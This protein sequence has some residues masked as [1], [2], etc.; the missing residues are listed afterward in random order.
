MLNKIKRIAKKSRSIQKLWKDINTKVTF[1]SNITEIT[2][3]SARRGGIIEKRLNLLVPSINQEHIFGGISTALKFYEQLADELGY[4]R[5]IITTDAAPSAEDMNHFKKYTLVNCNQ[6]EESDY[7]VVPF[8]D[9]YNKTVPIGENDLFMSTAWW[10]AYAAH[11]LI[12]WQAKEYE[13]EVKKSIYF[14]QDFEP[15]FY[16]WSSRYALADS[17]YRS[18][19]PQIAIFNTCLLYTSPSPRD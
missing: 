2:P 18:E 1:E 9:R 17:T 10:T 5:R 6:D 12:R 16:A 8:N 7:Q 3:I 13:Q 11:D 14:I 15:G 4:K 19:L